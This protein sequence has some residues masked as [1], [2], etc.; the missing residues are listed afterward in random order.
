MFVTL[1]NRYPGPFLCVLSARSYRLGRGI[2]RRRCSRA[3]GR[4]GLRCDADRFVAAEPASAICSRVDSCEASS[5]RNIVI[6]SGASP[7]FIF[8]FA[9]KKA[10]NIAADACIYTN[11]NFTIETIEVRPRL[12]QM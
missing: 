9:A 8:L 7:L 11:H 6:L 1:S 5:R 10:M 3:Q 2:R 12:P 4:A